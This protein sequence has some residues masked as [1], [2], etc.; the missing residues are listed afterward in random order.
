MKVSGMP[1]EGGRTG[2]VG[3]MP[4]LPLELDTELLVAVAVM[5]AR[6]LE[7]RRRKA[8]IIIKD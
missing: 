6:V 4:L 2:S 8:R 7:G 1:L 5:A 3:S